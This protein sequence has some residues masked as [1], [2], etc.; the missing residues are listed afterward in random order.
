MYQDIRGLAVTTASH[1]AA[2]AFDHVIDGY[3][4]Y[5]ADLPQRMAALL[6]ADPEFGL[7]HCLRGYFA[8]LSFKQAVVPMA[9]QALA[10]AWTF[11]N[12]ATPREQAHAAALEAW[13]DGHP[14]RTIGIWDQILAEHPHDVLAFRMAHF[15]NFW[16]GRPE[17]MLASVLAVEKRW[18]EAQPG[19]NAILG[20]RCFAHEESGYYTEAEHAGRE[21]IRRDPG[22]LWSAH[23]VAHVLEMTGRRREGIAWI[24][25]LQANWADGNNLRHHLWW[26]RAMY[27]LELGDHAAVLDLYDTRFRDLASPLVQAVP[28]L[29]IDLQNAA[30]MLFRLARHGVDVGNR[31]EEIADKAEA[32]IG[33]CLSGFTL[34]HLMMAL[35]ATGREDAARRMLEGMRDYAQGEGINARLVGE[36]A[37]PVTKAALAHGQ[38]RHAEAVAHMR[39]VLGEMYQLGGSHAQQDVLEQMFLDS[40]LKAGLDADVRMVMERVAGCHPVPPARRAGYAMAAGM[41]D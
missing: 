9:R 13:V 16:L 39:P 36:V 40:A 25:A 20:C 22:D 8:M 7:A 30:S 3:V 11:T 35:A 32:R 15:V 21:A 26:H 6:A 24:E 38:G 18:S 29:Y 37:L 27:H 41:L 12:G 34:P 5:R 28:D 17:A 31:W 4:R 19:Y 14:D 1:D 23:G 33:D 10:D 2:T